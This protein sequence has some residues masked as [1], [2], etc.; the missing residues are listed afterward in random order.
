VT[1]GRASRAAAE[2]HREQLVEA[3]A[4]LFREREAA[5]VSIPVVMSQIGLTRGGFYKHFDSKDALWAAAIREVFDQHLARITQL[6]ESHAEDPVA[7]HSAFVEFCLSS[8]HRDDPGSGCP[9]TLVSAVSHC[10]SDGAPRDAFAEGFREVL[11]EL[12]T[13]TTN[14]ADE[15]VGRDRLLVEIAT[16]TGAIL[17]ARALDG[18]PLSEEI[19]A[20][21]RAHLLGTPSMK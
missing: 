21:T 5:E 7:A 4:R 2:Q 6:W 9:G 17:L 19:L 13:R 15:H 20:A 16:M 3:A 1:L 10:D 11:Q 18:D 14:D 12:V 8:A